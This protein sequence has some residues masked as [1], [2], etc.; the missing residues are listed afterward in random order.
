MTRS[1]LWL[2][3]LTMAIVPAANGVC[4]LGCD[5]DRT[6]PSATATAAAGVQECP[7]HHQAGARRPPVPHTPTNRCGHDHTIVGPG[8][9][10]TS[11]DTPQPTTTGAATAPRVDA[12]SP[13][14]SADRASVAFR[15]SPSSPPTPRFVLRI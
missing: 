15:H 10:R 6:S 3:V 14:A 12:A 1:C 9:L 7:L 4:G 5:L 13:L 11:I 2:L 8:L